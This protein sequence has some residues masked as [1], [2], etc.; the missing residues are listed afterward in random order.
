VT[1]LED[2]KA[3]V[4]VV[5]NGGFNRAATQ[6]GVSKSI[7]S[8]RIARLE[9]E[10]GARLLS[11]TTRGVS[12]TEAGLELKERGERILTELEEAREAVAQ[13]SGE[14]VGRLRVSVP[15]SFVNYLAPILGDMACR[16]PKLELDA[17]FSD[18]PVDLVGERFDAAIRVGNLRDPNLIARRL[19]TVRAFAVAS[20]DYVERQGM[21][22][23]P[24]DLSQH[25][26][27]VY[28]GA[29]SRE[30][31]FEKG[32][33]ITTVRTE[34]RL[35][36]DNGDAQVAWALHGLGIA[37]LPAFFVVRALEEGK[38]VQLLG[39]YSL[40]ELGVYAVRPPGAYLPGKVRA[41]IDTLVEHFERFPLESCARAAFGK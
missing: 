5:E 34:G 19:A 22:R 13:Q 41:L 27:I 25:S 32:G 15:L 10:L 37:V 2:L 17:S 30:L 16:Y 24:D 38:L 9:E 1:D 28:T 36:A 11:R 40:P 29:A 39:D 31:H 33:T 23:I 21:P 8:R 6:L 18:R 20:P 26:C 3:F 7:V 4:A 14:V 35:R 12:P